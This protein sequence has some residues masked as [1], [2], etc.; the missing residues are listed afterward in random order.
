MPIGLSGMN[1][2]PS[3]NKF[4]TELLSEILTTSFTNILIYLIVKNMFFQKN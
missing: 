1:R 2:L 4:E 3:T